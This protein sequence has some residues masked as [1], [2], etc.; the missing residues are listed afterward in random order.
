MTNP[1]SQVLVIG[2]AVMDLVVQFGSTLAD[3]Q[4]VPGGSP[5]N[6]ALALGRLGVNV[7]LVTWF[8]DDAHGREIRERL[9]DSGVNIVEGSA[10]ARFTPTAAAHLDQEGAAQYT[11]NLDWNPPAPICL[12]P[13]ELIVHTGSI[14]A[15]LA[16]GTDTVLSAMSRA[17]K[18]A[19]TT[20]DPNSRPAI[21]GDVDE[22][23]VTV[24]NFLMQSDVVKVSDED[25][26]WLYP[27]RTPEESA[28]DW[29]KEFDIKLVV[30]TRG[31]KGPIAWT[32]KGAQAEVDPK[33]VKV[34]DTVGAGDTFMGGLIDAL[35]RR[36]LRG[37]DGAE[38]IMNLTSEELTEVLQDAAELADIVVQRRGANPPW[39]HEL[40]R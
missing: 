3:A 21:M 9:E 7:S 19:V 34:V 1:D 14:A 4:A 17:R 40:G 28:K 18:S 15:V 22:A 6:V 20:Y 8:G 23:R 12:T 10:G 29:V 39:A 27:D 30:M 5:A 2:E 16:P 24:E 25:L 37:P 38:K 32:P 11:F 33:K 35:W 26:E 31:G 13:D 36:D